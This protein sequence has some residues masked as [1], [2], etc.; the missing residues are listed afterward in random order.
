MIF[1]R[2]GILMVLA[3]LLVMGLTIYLL[4]DFQ[5]DT[6]EGQ[7]RSQGLALARL[8]SGVS[9]NELVPDRGRQG[10]LESL[11]KGQSN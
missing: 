8:L 5:K 2:T 4:S 1:Q 7:A 10:F 9:W 3:S 11:S 6:R